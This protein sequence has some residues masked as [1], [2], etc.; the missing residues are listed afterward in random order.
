MESYFGRL[1]QMN[2]LCMFVKMTLW[3]LWWRLK[4]VFYF[5]DSVQFHAEQASPKEM[6]NVMLTE[7]L[8]T[9]NAHAPNWKN[10]SAS[11]FVK[12]LNVSET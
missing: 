3:K 8:T 1:N 6:F 7:T 2:S 9:V 4:Y 5:F 12:C 11:S 10:Q